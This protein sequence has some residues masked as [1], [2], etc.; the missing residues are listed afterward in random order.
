[1]KVEVLHQMD[2]KGNNRRITIALLRDTS[3]LKAFNVKTKRL[4][5]FKDRDIL[6]T[7]NLYSMETF[8]VL[9]DMFNYFLN[10]PEIITEILHEEFDK[11]KQYSIATTLKV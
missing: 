7:E 10:D 9:R 6:E 5:S 1:M 2:A 8:T 3:G 4:I 11:I